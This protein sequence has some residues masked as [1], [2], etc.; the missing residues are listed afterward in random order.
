MLQEKYINPFTDFGFKR[1]FGEEANKDLLID[2]LNQLLPEKHQIEDLEFLKS[3][4]LG[5]T[6]SDR[7]AIFDLYCITPTKERFIVEMQ[8]AKQDFFKDRSVYYASFPIQEQAQQ[9]DWNFE[10]TPVYTVGILN[11]VFAEHKNDKE[12]FLHNVQLKDQNGQV[13]YDKLAFIYLELP[14][15]TKTIDQL[16]THFEKWLYVFQNLPLLEKMPEKWKDKVFQKLFK[17]AEIAKLSKEDLFEYHQS[18][19]Y[20][21]D[22]TNVIDTAKREGLEKGEQIGLEKG[23]QI[24]EYKK[25]VETARNLK[26]LGILTNIQISKVT[27]LSISE[28]EEL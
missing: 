28:V 3:E 10:L 14:K 20:L 11:F 4:R 5:A 26:K 16:E 12:T 23:E 1:L 7:K 6:P 2:F 25:A 15:F 17:V 18:L 8:K 21:R 19:K 22:M 9:G 13:F 24:G 27:N